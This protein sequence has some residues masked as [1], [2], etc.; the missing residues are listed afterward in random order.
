LFDKEFGGKGGENA[1]GVAVAPD[2]GSIYVTGTTTSFGAGFQ[3][4]FL[5]HLVPTGKKL[6]DAVTWGGTAFDTGGGVA[7]NGGT[8]IIGATT[9]A[10]PPYSLLAAAARLSAPRGTLAAVAGTLAGPAGVV[11]NPAAGVATPP[12]STTFSGNFEAALVRILR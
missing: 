9:N 3:D 8:V 12:G 2:D 10:G 1:D 11:A 7:V 4:A 5:L 6:L